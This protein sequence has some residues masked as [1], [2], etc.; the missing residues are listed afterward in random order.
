[1]PEMNPSEMTSQVTPLGASSADRGKDR[2]QRRSVAGRRLGQAA[3]GIDQD[4]QLPEPGREFRD[5]LRV[6]RITDDTAHAQFLGGQLDGVSVTAFVSGS[7][8]TTS[9]TRP[10]RSPAPR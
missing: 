1:M 10:P 4:V 9:S 8:S 7:Y 6:G 5:L 2:V 3:G